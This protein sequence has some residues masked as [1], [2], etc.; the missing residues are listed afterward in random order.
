[1]GDTSIQWTDKTWNPTRGCSRV[2][3][4]CVNCYAERIAERFSTHANQDGDRAGGV[5]AGFA[6]RVNGHPAWTGKVELIESK[7]T[8][9][10]HWK[11]PRRIFV[12]SMSDLFHEELHFDDISDV[13]NVMKSAPHHTYQILTKRAERMAALMPRLVVLHGILPCVWLGVS[14]EDQQRADERIPL[15]LQTP[16]AVRFVSY[17][18][19]LGPVDFSKWLPAVPYR[20]KFDIDWL[21]WII[22]GGESGPGAR[23]FDVAWARHCRDQCKAARVAFFFKQYG[24]QPRM[25]IPEGEH[26]SFLDSQRAVGLKS[27]AYDLRD[28]HG[29]DMAEWDEQDRVREFPGAAAIRAAV[30][31]HK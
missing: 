13:W 26:D 18:P 20:G 16:A 15:L 28:S 9:P 31:R 12:N 25:P 29:G 3:P 5:F 17:E 19:A 1:M 30:E 6:H 4:G 27:Y 2:S 7:L 14:V 8:E 11:K 23:P 21:D 10:L 22:V 24:A